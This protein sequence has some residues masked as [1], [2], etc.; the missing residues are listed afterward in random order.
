[1]KSDEDPGVPEALPR[2]LQMIQQRLGG[3]TVDRLW[4]FPGLK[5]GRQEW[6][7]VAVSRRPP[8]P[9]D[10]SGGGEDTT[11][12]PD[13]DRRVLYTAAYGAERT[14]QGLTVEH[15]LSEEGSAPL[16]RLPRIME[17]VVRRSGDNLGEPREV[18]VAFDATAFDEL[19]NE[20]DAELLEPPREPSEE[21]ADS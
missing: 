3:G 8:R 18:D 6:G 20:F 7:V 9:G 5:K 11:E 19:M 17:G 2:T 1:M 21:S 12:E 4:I 15:S 10:E 14:G 16:D 13:P